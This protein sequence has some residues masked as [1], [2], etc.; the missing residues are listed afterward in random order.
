MFR[1]SS[2][3]IITT[4]INTIEGIV[5]ELRGRG[6]LAKYVGVAEEALSGILN[7]MD[8]TGKIDVTR[9]V[10]T[11]GFYAVD[12]KIEYYGLDL[13]EPTDKD[14]IEC[15]NFMNELVEKYRRKDP[16]SNKIINDRRELPATILKWGI[17]APFNYVMKTKYNK[18]INWLLLCGHPSTAK[19]TLAKYALAL[20]RIHDKNWAI[21]GFAAANSEARF[22]K[23]ISQTT[24]PVVINE[25]TALASP[26]N[27]P[28][29]NVIKNSVDEVTARG[30]YNKKMRYSTTPALSAMLLTGNGVPPRDAGFRTKVPSILFT[31]EDVYDRQGTEAEE[32]R[33]WLN[34][35][36]HLLGTVGDIAA[37]YIMDRSDILNDKS[38][39]EIGI[40]VLEKMY[41][42]VNLDIPDWIKLSMTFKQLEQTTDEIISVLRGYFI[43]LINESCNR[44]R[45]T[46]RD[47]EVHEIQ[48]SFVRTWRELGLLDKLKGCCQRDLIPFISYKD[49]QFYINSGIM[50]DLETKKLDHMVSSHIALAKLLGFDYR[51]VKAGGKSHKMI[52]SSEE[53]MKGLLEQEIDN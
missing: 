51:V 48:D 2:G 16:V 44:Y 9:N 4:Q 23:H 38:W 31:N 13:R 24:L 28:L 45:P 14:I 5:A 39:D 32:F 37:K 21:V 40:E 10:E 36:M 27:E 12:D 35:Q 47:D 43:T 19:T 41:K 15:C 46:V 52:V 53:K 20:W 42:Q 34:P 1:T 11:Y 30:S 17:V 26:K 25:V 8:K 18:F 49:K 33:K 50:A 3:K 6:L 7:T 22:G 29:V